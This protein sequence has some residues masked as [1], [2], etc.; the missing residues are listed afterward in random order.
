MGWSVTRS[1]RLLRLLPA[2]LTAV[3]GLS[4]KRATPEASSCTLAV[5]GTSRTPVMS[6]EA[7]LV[8]V[9]VRVLGC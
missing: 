7:Y 3:V 8:R 9:R 6:W 2:L 4:T 1:I 5:R